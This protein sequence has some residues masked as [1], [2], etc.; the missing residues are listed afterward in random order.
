MIS[1]FSSSSC[2]SSSSNSASSKNSGSPSS[3]SVIR[4]FSA[5][6]AS[7]S[8]TVA[9]SSSVCPMSSMMTTSSRSSRR[10]PA[11]RPLVL[12][13]SRSALATSR[14]S[15]LATKASQ[16]MLTP[17]ATIGTLAVSVVLACHGASPALGFEAA[18][19]ASSSMAL[20]TMCTK[21]LESSWFDS[22]S[23]KISEPSG[24][25]NDTKLSGIEL[26]LLHIRETG[27]QG[28]FTMS[29]NVPLRIVRPT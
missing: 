29:S 4:P 14:R 15:V 6:C 20:I 23:S 25:L 8:T 17:P 1:S 5:L 13:T 7:V 2:R 21:M 3:T 24:M 19:R 28:C 11:V 10:I 22:V 27:P 16:K 12:P 18:S 26:G 9:G